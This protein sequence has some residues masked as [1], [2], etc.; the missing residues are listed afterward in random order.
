MVLKKCMG[1]GE[2]FDAPGRV[3]NFCK[4]CMDEW[5]RENCVNWDE[6]LNK[7]NSIWE[8]LKNEKEYY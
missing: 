4:P 2:M 5:R 1:C 8:R 7:K 6:I 3:Y